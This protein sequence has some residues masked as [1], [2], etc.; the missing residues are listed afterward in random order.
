MGLLLFSKRKALADLFY[1]YAEKYGIAEDAPEVIAY[2]HGYGLLNEDKCL[3]F[4]AVKTSTN[5]DDEGSSN[6]IEEET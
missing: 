3:E 5:M 2:L 6:N 1:E 4:L